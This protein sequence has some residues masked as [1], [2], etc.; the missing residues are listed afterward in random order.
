[1]GKR[2]CPSCRKKVNIKRDICNHCGFNIK[3]HLEAKEVSKTSRRRL[4][5]YVFVT[6]SIALVSYTIYSFTC[7]TEQQQTKSTIQNMPKPI[8]QDEDFKNKFV[9]QPNK[10]PRVNSVQTKQ[11]SVQC[12][13]M[14][15]KGKRCQRMTTD[16]SGYCFQHK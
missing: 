2:Y 8:S 3:Q 10:D 11:V 1:M 6:C 15:K 14:T 9:N 16:P 5:T 12:L 13:G 4:L 7:G